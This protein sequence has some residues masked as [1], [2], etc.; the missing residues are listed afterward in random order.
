LAAA[1][2]VIVAMPATVADFV[3]NFREQV[4]GSDAQ[5]RSPGN[6]QISDTPPVARNPARYPCWAG[7]SRF[8]RGFNDGGGGH[9]GA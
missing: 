2:V 8:G 3:G 6:A 1:T 7:D 9:H 4:G 5:C